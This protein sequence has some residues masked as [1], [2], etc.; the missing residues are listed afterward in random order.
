MLNDRQKLTRDFLIAM[1]PV[2]GDVDPKVTLARV[3]ADEV[4]ADK[5]VLQ[6]VKIGREQYTQTGYGTSR[7]LVRKQEF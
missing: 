7:A 4:L 5:E 1:L 6:K 2:P 3:L